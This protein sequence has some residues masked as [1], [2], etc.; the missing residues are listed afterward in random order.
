MLVLQ[1]G[2]TLGR[3]MDFCIW[4]LTPSLLYEN[5]QKYLL[6]VFIKENIFFFLEMKMKEIFHFKKGHKNKNVKDMNIVIQN[7]KLEIICASKV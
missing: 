6:F 2:L 1:F 3:L 4:I 7:D 5:T